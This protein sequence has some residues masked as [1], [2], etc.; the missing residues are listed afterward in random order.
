MKRLFTALVLIMLFAVPRMAAAQTAIDKPQ[1]VKGTACNAASVAGVLTCAQTSVPAG[2]LA[3][4]FVGVA[5]GTANLT[6]TE[7]SQNCG[8]TNHTQTQSA[9]S[10]ALT[11]RLADCANAAGGTYTWSSSESLGGTTRQVLLPFYITGVTATPF[12]SGPFTAHI[13]GT[14]ST[15]W[16]GA[17]TNASNLADTTEL[18]IE[19]F[20][21]V[22]AG[23]ST[24]STI[25]DPPWTLQNDSSAIGLQASDLT[26]VVGATAPLTGTNVTSAT[27]TATIVSTAFYISS[28]QPIIAPHG[29]ATVTTLGNVSSGAVNLPSGM[30]T[31]DCIAVSCNTVGIMS[32]PTLTGGGN[33]YTCVPNNGGSCVTSYNTATDSSVT[34]LGAE[35]AAATNPTITLGVTGTSTVCVSSAFSG[36]S[37]CAPDT[38]SNPNSATGSSGTATA[39]TDTGATV[40]DMLWFPVG[41]SASSIVLT[42]NSPIAVGGG[43][44]CG[45]SVSTTNNSLFGQCYPITATG[46]LPAEIA[47]ITSAPWSAQEVLISGA[48]TATPTPA[49]GCPG[50]FETSMGRRRHVNPSCP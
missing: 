3:G 22:A 21:R 49:A 24:I 34:F 37:N 16:N 2:A 19:F 40:N 7:T 26:V 1:F 46:T 47:H 13:N 31:G 27:S 11:V 43:T 38:N 30:S 14:A 15:T 4:V 50:G 10:P 39:P 18:V 12:D 44:W 6:I 45:G 20:G 48:P 35:T 36:V 17:P 25:T 41:L 23:G 42:G 5:S 28:V 29:T 9:S 32:S 33:T 8:P